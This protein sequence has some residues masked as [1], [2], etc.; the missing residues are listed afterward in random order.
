MI[1]IIMMLAMA[2]LLSNCAK[3]I[4]GGAGNRAPVL[5]RLI[6]DVSTIV[7]TP[8]SISLRNVECYDDDGDQLSI[9]LDT[10]ADYSVLGA[11][12]VPAP[13]FV[14]DLYVQVRVYDGTDYSNTK[15]MVVSVVNA[16]ELFPLISGSWWEYRDSVPTAD[17]ALHSRLEVSDSRDTVINAKSIPIRRLSW[18]NLAEYGV[19]YEAYTDSL[20]TVLLAGMA[21]SDTAVKSQRLIRYPLTLGDNW[22]YQAMS[23]NATDSV[24][25][26][27][28][29]ASITCTD[30]LVYVTVPA[31]IFACVEMTLSYTA[32]QS[33]PLSKST[34]AKI[35]T[36]LGGSAAASGTVVEKLYYSPGV[37]YVKNTVS[38][39]GVSTWI[40]ELTGYKVE[41]AQ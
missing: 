9:V 23:Y 36:A 29:T 8:V 18:S 32:A 5:V 22:Q 21:P 27:G 6:T 16:V 7:N 15:I 28:D 4:S 26:F 17:S 31:G 40:K 37:G 1:R 39:N 14:G 35:H 41:E 2:L 19:S 11:E 34:L 24:F 33:A 12:V 13:D 38:V 20:G 30:T 10:G 3:E 25:F